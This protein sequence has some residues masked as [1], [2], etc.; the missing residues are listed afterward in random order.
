MSLTGIPNSGQEGGIYT[1][2]DFG[3]SNTQSIQVSPSVNTTYNLLY[4]LNGCEIEDSV[5]IQVDNNPSLDIENDTICPGENAFLEADVTPSGGSYLWSYQGAASNSITP[6][7][8]VSTYYTLEYTLGACTVNDSA[9][10]FILPLP[11][12]DPIDTLFACGGELFDTVYFNSNIPGSSFTWFHSSPQIGLVPN[13]GTG[14]IFAWTAPMN[15]IAKI[16]CGFN[17]N[18]LVY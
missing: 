13:N 1:W 16:N 3:S 18:R 7:P 12:V 8:I 5:A 2:N 11:Q 17:R 14:N 15:T 9:E 4:N 6:D 10:V